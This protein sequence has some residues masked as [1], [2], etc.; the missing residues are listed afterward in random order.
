MRYGWSGMVVESDLSLPGLVAGHGDAAP[1]L[2][3]S[4]REASDV[5]AQTSAVGSVIA[6]S[7][8]TDKPD[9][10][11]IRATDGSVHLGFPGALSLHLDPNYARA[12]YAVERGCGPERAADLLTGVALPL[13]LLLRGGTAI[14]AS[15][16]EHESRGIAFVGHSGSGKSTLSLACCVAGARMVTEDTAALVIDGGPRCLVG[17]TDIRIRRKSRSLAALVPDWTRYSSPDGREA[18]LPPTVDG[19]SSSIDVVVLPKPDR[20]AA[21]PRL[22]RLSGSEAVIKL[23]AAPRVFGVRDT[24]VVRH[25]FETLA[26]LAHS[27]PVLV[28]RLPWRPPFT[29]DLG[30]DL[31]RSLDRDRTIDTRA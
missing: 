27:V 16:V 23:L 8:S 14:H 17:R 19:L 5:H 29:A 2:S 3:I 25:Q 1:D 22:H 28:A 12:T 4:A 7:N 21:E 6:R 15:V 24:T 30:V 20:T 13:V 9:Y 18:I 26:T 11:A 10:R 31:L